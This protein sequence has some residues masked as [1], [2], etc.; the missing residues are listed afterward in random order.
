MIP[1]SSTVA[2]HSSTTTATSLRRPHAERSPA[3]GCRSGARRWLLSGPNH[4]KNQTPRLCQRLSISLCHL[5]ALCL[6][7]RAT[8][9]LAIIFAKYWPIFEIFSL[10]HSVYSLQ[11]HDYQIF[12]HTLNASMR[13][14]TTLSNIN[15]LRH[16][17]ECGRCW[18]I[19]CYNNSGCRKIVIGST[20]DRCCHHGTMVARVHPVHLMNAAWQKV[21]ANLWTKPVM[22]INQFM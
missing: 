7:K 10:A 2:S 1:A 17:I 4:R 22:H 11:W 8:L 6:K 12:H 3:P 18:K 16:S 9:S 21:T 15:F 14:Y 5:T 13:R 19:S 20:N